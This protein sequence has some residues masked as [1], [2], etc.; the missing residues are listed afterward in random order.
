MKID[1]FILRDNVDHEFAYLILLEKEVDSMK[2]QKII[3]KVKE[4]D[5]DE[6]TDETIYNALEKELKFKKVYDLYFTKTFEY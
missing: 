6:Y 1:R 4:E 5:F 2:V 3:D